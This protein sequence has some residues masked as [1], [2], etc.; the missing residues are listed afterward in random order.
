MGCVIESGAAQVVAVAD[1][2]PEAARTAATE[3]GAEIA[4][5]MGALCRMPI[6][7]IMIATPSAMHAEQAITALRAGK[8][9]FCQKPLA[10]SAAETAAVIA[11]A[12]GSGRLL[13][14]DFSYR[15][16][17]GVP[18]MRELV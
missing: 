7:G 12:R 2:D 8:S 9:V 18:Q 1:T 10:R 3:S 13:G 16:V 15:H 11:A 4:H 5:D 14:V 17:G 6:D